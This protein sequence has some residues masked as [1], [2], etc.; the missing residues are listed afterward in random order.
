MTDSAPWRVLVVCVGN[1]CRSPL[2]ERLLRARLGVAGSELL[3]TSAGTRGPAGMPMDADA[4]AQLGRLGGDADG[5]LSRRIS[6]AVLAEQDLV[7][8]AT[9]HLRT[10]VL[11]MAPRLMRRSFT[12]VE[13][14]QIIRTEELHGLAP[15]ALVAAAATRRARVTADL[16]VADPIGASLEVHR[17][18]ADQLADCVDQ[19]AGALR[20]QP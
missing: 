17:Q 4:A 13:L 9:R 3:V 5:F 20:V 15:R 19:I 2:A 8:T 14:A 10:E 12:I 11:R 7:L 1:Q 18:V 6:P 16:D